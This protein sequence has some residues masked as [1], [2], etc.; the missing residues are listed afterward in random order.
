M[1]NVLII[2]GGFGGVVAAESLAQRLDPEH[3]IT[4]VSLPEMSLRRTRGA[5]LMIC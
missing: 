1:A 3:Q 2:G 5:S 4:L